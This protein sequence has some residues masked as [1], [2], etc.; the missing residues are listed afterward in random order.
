MDENVLVHHGVVGMK[1]GVRRYQNADGSL[2][3]EGRHHYGYKSGLKYSKRQLNKIR[4]ERQEMEKKY[5]QSNSNYQKAERLS[6]K[7]RRLSERHD[8]VSD[9]TDTSKKE[10][11]ARKK[12]RELW[13]QAEDLYEAAHIESAKQAQEYIENKYGKSAV[14]QLAKQDAVRAGLEATTGILAT[15]GSM[16]VVKLLLQGALK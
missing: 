15:L 4:D 13:N 16:H 11:R 6:S 12:Y 8:L 10:T 1:W 3:A 2:T 7:A 14:K 9:E 5:E